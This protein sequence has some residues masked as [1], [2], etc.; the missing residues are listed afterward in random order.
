MQQICL[1]QAFLRGRQIPVTLVVFHTSLLFLSLLS[2][3]KSFRALGAVISFALIFY[4]T[5]LWSTVCASSHIQEN[6]P[7]AEFA[8]LMQK[9]KLAPYIKRFQWSEHH[10]LSGAVGI[11]GCSCQILWKLDRN[12]PKESPGG[13]CVPLEVPVSSALEGFDALSIKVSPGHCFHPRLHLLGSSFIQF[14]SQC[15]LVD[16]ELIAVSQTF[17]VVFDLWK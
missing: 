16:P 12:S 15:F 3:N 8:F 7:R 6:G 4:K 9:F 10:S 5:H 17:V 1:S 14:F 2:C 11:L 13:M